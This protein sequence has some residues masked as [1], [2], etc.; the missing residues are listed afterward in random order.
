VFPALQVR[1][2]IGLFVLS[3]AAATGLQP[4]FVVP[5]SA[6]EAGRFLRRAKILVPLRRDG[7]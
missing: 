6:A 7:G 2:P 4:F 5:F 3:P 1:F